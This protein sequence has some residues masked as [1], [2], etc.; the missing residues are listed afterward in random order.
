MMKTPRTVDLLARIHGRGA[1]LCGLAAT[2][3][4]LTMV[5]PA[6]A[7]TRNNWVPNNGELTAPG[8]APLGDVWL[9]ACPKGGQVTVSVDTADD[10]GKGPSGDGAAN[11]EPELTVYNKSGTPIA[12][13]V[14]P[15]D[16][17]Y[18]PVCG[19]Q[20][21]S[22]TVTCSKKSSAT[23]T[24]VV[25]DKAG[26]STCVGGGGYVLRVEGASE[27][28][29]KLGGGP[30]VKIPDW[31]AAEGVRRGPVVDDGQVPPTPVQ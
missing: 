22:Q 21:S 3:L 4:A 25:K 26:D 13:G 8:E 17:T 14:T 18:D 20:C 10:N 12:S 11:L 5:Q 19:V 27:R 2:V 23:Y 6:A 28:K 24:I 15:A 31:A 29:L 30:K 9:F 7:A 16:C 1:A